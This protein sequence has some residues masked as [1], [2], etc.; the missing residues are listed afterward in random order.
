MLLSLLEQEYHSLWSSIIN[1]TGLISL[2]NN[3]GINNIK[4]VF[5]VNSMLM[6]L[7]PLCLLQYKTATPELKTPEF[8]VRV[9]TG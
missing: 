2:T 6:F 3:Y 7:F 5:T 8:N 1:F 4:C 9:L